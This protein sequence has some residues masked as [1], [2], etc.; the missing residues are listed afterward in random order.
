M[1]KGRYKRGPQRAVMS[2]EEIDELKKAVSDLSD[3]LTSLLR[4]QTQ[5]GAYSMSALGEEAVTYFTRRAIV[6]FFKGTWERYKNE[7]MREFLGRIVCSDMG[8]AYD[9]WKDKMREAQFCSMDEDN[10][11]QHASM[12]QSNQELMESLKRLAVARDIGYSVAEERVKDDPE[13]LR[14]LH[15]MYEQ[16]S[17]RYISKKLRVNMDEVKALEKRLLDRLA[18]MVRPEI[19]AELSKMA[20]MAI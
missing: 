15:L 10:R 9:C 7:T 17:Y 19:D 3:Y 16:D 6:T 5:Y 13:L 18:G 2:P 8:H 12:E 14:Y 1:N 20:N 11:K 4:N